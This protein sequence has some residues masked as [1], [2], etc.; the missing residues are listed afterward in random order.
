MRKQPQITVTVAHLGLA[1]SPKGIALC[2]ASEFTEGGVGC[3]RLHSFT[4]DQA[5]S[6]A[7]MQGWL[8]QSFQDCVSDAQENWTINAAHPDKQFVD[9]LR[10]SVGVAVKKTLL[11]WRIVEPI[12]KTQTALALIHELVESG[13]LACDIGTIT[14]LKRELDKA[15]QIDGGWIMEPPIEAL[16]L[17]LGEAEYRRVCQLNKRAS[18]TAVRGGIVPFNPYARR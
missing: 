1:F 4:V 15:V 8:R 18:S 11:R 7:V 9:S 3:Y 17:C 13:R 2:L 14:T 12:S 6:L 10:R 16:A 5:P